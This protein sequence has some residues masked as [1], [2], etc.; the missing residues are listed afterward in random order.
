MSSRST[1]SRGGS[2]NQ[3]RDKLFNPAIDIEQVVLDWI[4]NI[5][6]SAI[7]IQGQGDAKQANTI[8]TMGVLNLD[9]FV[10]SL[11]TSDSRK[12]WGAYNKKRDDI[13]GNW[14]AEDQ[15]KSAQRARKLFELTITIWAE[16]KLF[17]VRRYGYYGEGWEKAKAAALDIEA[18]QDEEEKESVESDDA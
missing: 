7:F 13:L 10:H 18:M 8:F 2:Q 9:A 6:N 11:L 3:G 15:T 4:H 1:S 14:P 5:G 12:N 16:Q 17:K